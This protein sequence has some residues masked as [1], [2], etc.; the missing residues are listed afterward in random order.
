MAEIIFSS[1]LEQ[2]QAEFFVANEKKVHDEICVFRSA[3]EG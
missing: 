3:Q 2:K 1:Q